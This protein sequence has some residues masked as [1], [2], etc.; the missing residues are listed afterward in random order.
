MIASTCLLNQVLHLRYLAGTSPPASEHHGLNHSHASAASMK[1]FLIGGLIKKGAV[2][3]NIV[4]RVANGFILSAAKGR[5]G[6][7]YGGNRCCGRPVILRIFMVSPPGHN[8]PRICS[9]QPRPLQTGAVTLTW[10]SDL[11]NYDDSEAD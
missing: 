2:D 7:G 3:T 9:Y 1:A 8:S 10:P 5:P 4:L 11:P 6:K